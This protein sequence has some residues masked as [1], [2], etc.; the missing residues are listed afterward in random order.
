MKEEIKKKYDFEF[1]EINSKKIDTQSKQVNLETINKLRTDIDELQDKNTTSQ[2]KV[3]ETS[4]IKYV[5]NLEYLSL[6]NKSPHQ[7]LILK[8]KCKLKTAKIVFE[9]YY[10]EDFQLIRTGIYKGLF[11]LFGSQLFINFY[12]PTHPIKNTLLFIFALTAFGT[13]YFSWKQNIDCI[14]HQVSNKSIN[15]PKHLVDI[16]NLRNEMM[17]YN[18]FIKSTKSMKSNI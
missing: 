7:I 8:L 15:H 3:T 10:S 17:L 11:I 13:N 6:V 5:P 16:S 12:I 2:I 9:N 4:M 18:P 1:P 14:V